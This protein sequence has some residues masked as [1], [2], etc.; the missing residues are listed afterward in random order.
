LKS[1]RSSVVGA[2]R[3]ELQQVGYGIELALASEVSGRL[4]LASARV[5]SVRGGRSN[6]RL[7]ARLKA[8]SDS[9]PRGSTLSNG[10]TVE[11][12]GSS[13]D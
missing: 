10:R 6:S 4:A 12:L 13:E 9:Y 3:R 5:D 11:V 1:G 7:N 2:F 8:A